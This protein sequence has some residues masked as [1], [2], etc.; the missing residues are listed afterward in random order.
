MAK[1]NNQRIVLD[2]NV[3]L[4]SLVQRFKYHWIF[5]KLE[6]GE[7]DLILSTDIILEYEEKIN[8]KFGL[9]L[10]E[11]RL[12]FLLLFPNVELVNPYHNWNLISQDPDD[13]K[14]VDA[15]VS[16][17]AD[18]LVTNDKH[19]RVLKEIE[20]PPINVISVDEFQKLLEE[21]SP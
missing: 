4:V 19:F 15:A 13:N 14:F 20:F 8:E 17:N 16:G 10:S 11:S 18:F 5:S 12:E 1:T 6:A 2:T 9:E 21:E 7:Y 3:F